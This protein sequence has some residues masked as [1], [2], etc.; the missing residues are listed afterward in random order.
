M[1][2]EL[3]GV[4]L[5]LAVGE[6]PLNG[7][8]LG[9]GLAERTRDPWRSTPPS[10]A[11][12]GPRPSARRRS[13]RARRRE[14]ASC[15]ESP[16]RPR[17]GAGRRNAHVF[18]RDLDGVARAAAVLFELLAG[19]VARRRVSTMNAVMPRCAGSSL[20]AREHDAEAAHRALRDEHLGA[21]DQPVVAVAHRARARRGASEPEPGSVSAQAAS[22]SPLAARQVLSL[23]RFGTARRTWPVPSP[24]WLAIVS[25]S[26]PSTRAPSSTA[27]A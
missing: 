2:Q 24:L 17:P 5:G 11:R 20:V 23:L 25:A 12:R 16:D 8:K 6:Q 14:C 13:R 7:L 26:E 19:G 9:D 1:D 3:C 21:V 18:E 15:P 27:I 10:R 22:H 4:E